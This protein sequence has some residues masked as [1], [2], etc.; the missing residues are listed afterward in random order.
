MKTMLGTSDVSSPSGLALLDHPGLNKDTA[1]TPE[2]REKRGLVGLLPDVVEDLE[3]QFQR[4][5]Y[6]LAQKPTPIEEY[7]FLNGLYEYNE[8]LFF[9]VVMSD[10]KRFLPI[11]YDP[12]VAEACIKFGHIYRRA[13]GMYLSIKHRGRVKEVLRNWP[14]KDVRFICAS[15]G[16]RIL[17]LGDIG[18][19]GMG[20]PIGKLQLYTACAGVPPDGLLP[21]LIDIGTTNQA[22]RDDPLY[23]GLRQ[24]PPSTDGLDEFVDEFME[25]VQDVFPSCCVHFEDW[26]GTDALRLLARYTNKYLCYNDDIQG[27]ASVTLAGLVTALQI[28]GGKLKDQTILFEGAGSA[29]VGIANMIVTAMTLEGLSKEDA[30]KRITLFDAGGLL[31][32]SRKDLNEWQKPYVY[33]HA[34]TK[35][36]YEAV[37]S[38]KPNI[39]IGVSTV[40]G[41]FTKA[42]VEEM[43]KNNE[44]PIIFALSN[45]TDKAECTAEQAYGGSDG[46]A[47]FAAGVQFP[48]VTV[49]G[50]TFEPGQANNF[51]V[52]PAVALAVYLTRPKRVTDEMF[53]A[54]AQALAEQVSSQEREKGLL[55]PPQ[56]DVFN[57][58]IRTAMKVA[59][60]IFDKSLA[61]VEEPVD[62]VAW[63]EAQVYKPE[64]KV[65][66]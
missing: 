38:L 64:Y 66:V 31:E 49:H 56:R 7:I 44:R 8:T 48:E 5:T 19:N 59:R 10:P 15:S 50:K 62:L 65:V 39:L 12:T 41:T 55:F 45:P 23:L 17:G 42:V 32:S 52:Y 35:D 18:T 27:T 29:G 40:G 57:V 4:A 54:A 3:R 53:I 2:E 61:T 47:L 13:Q 11:V 1:F 63:T 20:I 24:P 43:S 33:E 60:M 25:A 36:L 58:E 30:Q 37:Q 51:Y 28:K 9:K 16:G 21:M 26:K 22:L 46:R 14:I 34:P 6:Q